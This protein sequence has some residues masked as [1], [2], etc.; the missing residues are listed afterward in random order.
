MKNDRIDAQQGAFSL[1]STP[2]VK[3]ADRPADQHFQFPDEVDDLFDYRFWRILI[4]LSEKKSELLNQLD[5]LGINESPLFP[6][7]EHKA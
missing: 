1:F 3:N 2:K 7:L 4:V 5:L 6:D